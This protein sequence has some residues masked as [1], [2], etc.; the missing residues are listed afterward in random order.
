MDSSDIKKGFE[1]AASD[2]I[3]E[4]EK[5]KKV[6][7]SEDDILHIATI[8]ANNDEDIGE[9]IKEAFVNI[10]DGGLVTVQ[11]NFQRNGKTEV[12]E[13]LCSFVLLCVCIYRRV[14]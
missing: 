11:P 4:L 8:S 3:E 10:G 13:T 1:K 5:Q 9:V 7:E 2:L 6:I 12:F 14:V